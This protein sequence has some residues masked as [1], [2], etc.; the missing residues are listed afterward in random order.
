M[1]LVMFSKNTPPNHLWNIWPS[2][3]KGG[4]L[5]EYTTEG[6][7]KVNRWGLLK[8]N[9]TDFFIVL[10]DQTCKQDRLSII[11]KLNSVETDQ[12]D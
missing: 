8:V 12:K 9:D 6:V 10:Q 5:L 1:L 7:H 3:V 4:L 2:M 11:L